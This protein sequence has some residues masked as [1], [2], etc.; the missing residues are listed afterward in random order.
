[1]Q[2]HAELASSGEAARAI[3]Q[4]LQVPP[5][6]VAKRLKAVPAQDGYFFEVIGRDD[7]Q[8]KATQLVTAAQEVYRT[9]AAR[10]ASSSSANLQQLTQTRD[11]FQRDLLQRRR[12]ADPEDIAA[13]AVITI[14]GQQ[15][16]RLNGLISQAEIDSKIGSSVVTLAEPPR[17][18]GQVAPSLFVNVL[19]GGL[20]GLFASAAIIW[21]RYLR[22][23]TVLDGRSAADAIG[24]PLIAGPSDNRPGT[25]LST[26][27]LVAAMAAVL[28]PTVKVVAL[29]PAGAG[30]L[31]SETVAAIAANWSDDQGVVL[32]LDASPTSDVRATLERL[33]RATSGELPRW[34][35]EPTCLARSSGSGRGHVLYNRVSPSRAARPGGLAPILADRAPVVD[36]VILLTP[37]LAD[38]PMTA[39]SALQADAV[40]VVTSP[41]TRMYELTQ[42]CRDWPALAERVVGVIHDTRSGFRRTGGADG[43]GRSPRTASGSASSGPVLVD[44]DTRRSRS[45]RPGCN[46]PLR[47]PHLLI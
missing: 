35:H 20:V 41:E 37:P 4:K 28:S 5:E 38:L 22:R 1:V 43:G 23:P 10:Y 9:L 26:D 16:D 25:E 8:V 44:S 40:V 13:Q 47:P 33:P 39:A 15:I 36:L 17:E 14:R 31:L 29:T 12:T 18:E 21:V 46:R 42:V 30:D 27:M 11:E 3:A 7:T 19:L 32:V 45:T 24:A 34:A 6:Y 2:T